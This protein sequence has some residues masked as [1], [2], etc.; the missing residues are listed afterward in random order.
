MT[1]I[2][3]RI[4]TYLHTQVTARVHARIT[5]AASHQ[6]NWPYLSKL[7]LG[8]AQ[9]L[10]RLEECLF[11]LGYFDLEIGFLHLEGRLLLAP[12]IHKS[13]ALLLR[14]PGVHVCTYVCMIYMYLCKSLKCRQL[15]A[16][17]S[18]CCRAWLCTST[19]TV[20]LTHESVESSRSRNFVYVCVHVRTCTCAHTHMNIKSRNKHVCNT[21]TNQSYKYSSITLQH[22]PLASN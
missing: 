19:Y 22:S 6:H 12:S 3:L 2:R 21:Q 13:P 17:A 14:S 18:P 8:S 10:L 9:L 20:L 1:Y 7:L 11:D 15:S 4:Y 16:W 5:H